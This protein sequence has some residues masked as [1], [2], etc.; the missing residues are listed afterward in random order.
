[1][2]RRRRR[3]Y[4]RA[5]HKALCWELGTPSVSDLHRWSSLCGSESS[6]QGQPL[7]W[8][9][10]S[11]PPYFC[12]CGLRVLQRAI[13]MIEE[14]SASNFLNFNIIKCN[15]MIV[16]RKQSPIV[17]PLPLEL[18]NSPMQRVDCCK[19]LGLLITNN[20]MWSAHISSICSN[21]KKILGLIYRCFYTCSN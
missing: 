3:W 19:Y 21:T 17:P 14:W 18:F 20:L 13:S 11:L 10:S 12:F 6:L 5:S 1:M 9:H 15:Y 7:C 8:R 2:Q 16:S 4:T